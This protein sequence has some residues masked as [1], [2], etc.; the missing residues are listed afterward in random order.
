MIEYIKNAKAY[1]LPCRNVC[2]FTSQLTLVD[3]SELYRVAYV[4]HLFTVTQWTGECDLQSQVERPS[5]NHAVRYWAMQYPRRRAGFVEAG[6]EIVIKSREK[7]GMTLRYGTVM[8]AAVTGEV[9]ATNCNETAI[10]QCTS[11]HSPFPPF[12]RNA[13]ETFCQFVSIWCSSW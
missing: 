10:R 13:M 1:K 4:N 7:G 11:E 5:H 9:T 8:N 6:V 3:I 2:L 12:D